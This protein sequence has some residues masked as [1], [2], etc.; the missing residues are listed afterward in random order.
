VRVERLV[1]VRR[2]RFRFLVGRL[3]CQEGC[4]HVQRGRVGADQSAERRQHLRAD[5]LLRLGGQPHDQRGE[6]VRLLLVGTFGQG[7]A[8]QVATGA[9]GDGHRTVG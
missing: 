8:G 4:H 1:R 3:W 6:L 5:L 2:G 7:Q 9:D